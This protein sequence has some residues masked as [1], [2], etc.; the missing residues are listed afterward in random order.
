MKLKFSFPIF[1][2]FSFLQAQSINPP[3]GFMAVFSDGK[4][5]PVTLGDGLKL[6][7]INGTLQ[8]QVVLPVVPAPIIPSSPVLTFFS[9]PMYKLSD[10]TWTPSL[11]FIGTIVPGSF[12]LAKNGVVQ[13]DNY[14]FKFDGSNNSIRMLYPM[15]DDDRLFFR[16]ATIK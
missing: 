5:E 12:V 6:V 9:S 15:A 10:G 1:L 16:F 3:I 4:T 8:L 14:D 2:L 11:P 7:N 13:E